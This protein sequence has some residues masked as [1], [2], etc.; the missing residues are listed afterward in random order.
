MYT[1][2]QQKGIAFKNFRRF[3]EFPMLEFGDITYMVGRNNSG[4]STMVKALLLTLDYLQNQLSD[5]FSFDNL[6]LEDANIV[7]FGRAK[8]NLID[9]P[10]IIF[11]LKLKNYNIS[12]N[13]SGIDG[14]TKANVNLLHIHDEN[15]GYSLKVNYLTNLIQITKKSISDIDMVD[16]GEEFQ[17]LNAEINKLKESQKSIPKKVSKEALQ[18][19]DQI[20]KLIER[21]NKIAHITEYP[22]EE[23]VEYSLEYPLNY[24]EKQVNNSLDSNLSEYQNPIQSSKVREVDLNKFISN[25]DGLTNFELLKKQIETAQQELEFAINKRFSKALF[26]NVGDGVLKEE[27]E[28]LFNKYEN[29]NFNYNNSLE[30]LGTIQVHIDTEETEDELVLIKRTEDNELKELVSIFLYHNSI[31]YIQLLDQRADSDNNLEVEDDSS[32]DII[33]LDNTQEDLKEWINDLVLNLDN[34]EF[35]YLGANPS[36][37]SALF[38][39]RDKNNALA[40]AIHEFYQLG[41]Q[42]GDKEWEFVKK[43]MSDKIDEKTGQSE[44]FEVG[45]NFKINFLSGEA[46]EFKVIQTI[47][48]SLNPYNVETQ[49]SDKGMGSLQAMLLILRVASLIRINKKNKQAITLLVEEPELNLHP[50]LQSKLTDFFHEVNREFGFNFIIETHSEYIIRNSQLLGLKENYFTGNVLDINPFKVYYFHKE[51]GPYEMKYKDNGSFERQFGEGFLDVVDD[52]A[53]EMFLQN[54]QGN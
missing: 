31:A 37:Q 25:F 36:K 29:L 10:E 40:Q 28:Q 18:I 6:S 35:F 19:A 52:I 17:Q 15:K 4:K 16:T 22:I 5:T 9:E 33:E 47:T 50:A 46:Y 44:G 48:D 49:L 7:T 34:E 1:T 42:E 12:I 41:I 2:N 39:L 13:I 30:G 53:L 51:N 21:R 54:N 24:Q 23:E 38:Q 8:C 45:N 27:L 14:R 43:W 20:N 26:K 11:D 3:K 32:S